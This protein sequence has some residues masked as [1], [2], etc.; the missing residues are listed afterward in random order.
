[1]A[2]GRLKRVRWR[3]EYALFRTFYAFL[4]LLPLGAA[5]WVGRRIGDIWFWADKRHRDIGVRQIRERLGLDETEA[6]RCIRK[7]FRHF[8]MVLAEFCH[9]DQMNRASDF[10]DRVDL[11]GLPRLIRE[12]LSRGKGVI[13]VT[14]H[15]GNWEMI[16]TLAAVNGLTGASIARPLDNPLLNDF[17]RGVR[18]RLGMRVLDK[19]GAIRGAMKLLQGNNVVGLLVDQD[20]GGGIHAIMSPFFGTLASTVTTPVQMAIR[21]GAPILVGIAA[22]TGDKD[23]RF[24]MRYVPEPLY[25]DLNADRERET[26][27]LVD[28]INASLEAM[29]R[30]S[31]EQWLWIHRRWKTRELWNMH[32]LKAKY[33]PTGRIE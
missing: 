16:N 2:V 29:I 30:R 17:A 15:Y 27:R 20:A 11:C 5:A 31:P 24:V 22:R 14:G 21:T 6:V 12:L 19:F 33:G 18:E 7:T 26:Q 10:T 32:P 1:M 8:G 28:A 9:L 13:F 4:S 3:T 23:S 25:P